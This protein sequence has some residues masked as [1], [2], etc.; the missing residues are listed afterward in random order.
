MHDGLP[1]IP[2]GLPHREPFLFV[3]AVTELNPQVSASGCRTFPP[4][5][6]VFRGHFPGDPIVPGVLLVEALAQMSGIAASVPD[7]P[8]FLLSGIRTMKFPS[9]AL[10]GELV[11]LFATCAG[12]LGGHFLFDVRAAVGDRC[13]AEGRVIL[14]RR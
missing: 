3:D 8:G 11:A 1:G 4:D 13:V 14:S 2:A 6:P 10:P 12:E 7:G 5:D 9:S